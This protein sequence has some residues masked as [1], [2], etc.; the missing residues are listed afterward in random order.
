MSLRQIVVQ[1]F[2]NLTPQEIA[3]PEGVVAVVGD[4]GA[5]K[6]NLL[7][8]V[9][10]LGNLLSFRPGPPT[11]W[12]QRDGPGFTLAGV[13]SREGTEVELR[14]EARRARSL[15]RALFRGSRRLGAAEYLGLCPVAVLSSHDR[16]LVWGPP[17]ERR[18]FLDRIA[19]FLHPATLAV[20]QRYRRAL[21]QRNALLGGG[22]HDE[23]LDAFEHD[24]A[25][26]GAR[27]VE[28]RGEALAILER[29]IDDELAA[30]GWGLSRPNLRYDSPEG[31]APSDA[32]TL[33]TRMRAEL[34]RRRRED[35]ARGHTS[36]GPHRH[37][38]A[39][40]VAGA[41]AR[42]VLSAGQGKLLA[43]A[44]KL[45]A[46]TVVERMR[47]RVPT[48]VFD[49]V[50]AELDAR[51][52]ERVLARLSG[53]GQVLISSAHEEMLLARVPAATVWRVREGNVETPAGE[54]VRH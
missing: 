27:L 21:R 2:R 12:V 51:V 45:A 1:G 20:A 52:L 54:G 49:D 32:A 25:L 28:L 6:T 31:F 10:V 3:I 53:T 43:T 37:D 47:G 46:V 22:G 18:R 9:A 35:R 36:V 14:Q 26:L 16:Q 50:D 11:S 15:I 8:A 33:A 38:L 19:F 39:I 44:C 24:L 29:L 17:E 42:E 7:E 5:G 48:V 41:P 13:V 40:S 23:A 4:N 30:L 34:T